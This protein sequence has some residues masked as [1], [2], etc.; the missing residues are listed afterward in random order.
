M[1]KLREDQL[2]NEFV[3]S[4]YGQRMQRR[5]SGGYDE[6]G[7][8]PDLPSLDVDMLAA[9]SS[10]IVYNDSLSLYS[11][12]LKEQQA[13]VGGGG[14]GEEDALLLGLGLGLGLG[15]ALLE[16]AGGSRSGVLQDAA[17]VATTGTGAGSLGTAQ[18]QTSH[19][20]LISLS[21]PQQ[22]SP[23]RPPPDISETS[24]AHLDMTSIISMNSN[25]N[26][27]NGG[28]GEIGG[29]SVE[30]D[31]NSVNNRSVNSFNNSVNNR[32]NNSRG[33]GRSSRYKEKNDIEM[34]DDAS[35]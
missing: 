24:A 4:R 16:P 15:G 35:V 22:S 27:S 26:V 9:K 3:D 20:R 10:S 23:S 31:N 8:D 14:G 5:S 1:E 7:V 11:D 13:A 19:Q 2:I 29:G 30:N 6:D 12:Y 25:N 18:S 33:S 28:G 17:T 32:E 21:L 34:D